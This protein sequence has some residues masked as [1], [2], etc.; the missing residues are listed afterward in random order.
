MD[1]IEYS[2][3]SR[4]ELKIKFKN[5]TYSVT[6]ELVLD[7]PKFYADI[8]SLNKIELNNEDKKG[9]IEYIEMDSLK[10]IGTE[11]VFD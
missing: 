3:V 5:R 9:I 11:I 2:I 1:Q 8:A 6:G 4:G 10:N 7:P